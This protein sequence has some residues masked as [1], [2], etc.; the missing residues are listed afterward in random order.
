MATLADI[1]QKVQQGTQV[2]SGID[3][4]TPE[5]HF[6]VTAK[7][8]GHIRIYLLEG[9]LDDMDAPIKGSIKFSKDQRHGLAYRS[10]DL[11]GGT[12]IGPLTDKN[13]ARLLHLMTLP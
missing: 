8:S 1:H 7:I 5:G 11:N 12:V 6:Q 3:T 10:S 4:V 13:M 2:A 9:A